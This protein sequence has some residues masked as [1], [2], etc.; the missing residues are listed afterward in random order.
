MFY[1]LF[2]LFCLEDVEFAIKNCMKMSYERETVNVLKE[3][4]FKS[5]TYIEWSEIKVSFEMMNL[6]IL[7]NLI[8]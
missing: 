5:L 7:I 6:H 4:V 8:E 1:F 3:G 2:L